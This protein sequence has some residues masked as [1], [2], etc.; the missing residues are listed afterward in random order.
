MIVERNWRG[1]AGEVDLIVTD[2]R[3]LVI[4]EVKARAD[5]RFGGAAAAVGP[6]KQRRLRALAA[7]F[8]AAHREHRGAVRFDVVAITGRH[9]VGVLTPSTGPG[10]QPRKPHAIRPTARAMAAMT[11]TM[12]DRRVTRRRYGFM[13]MP[14][15]MAAGSGCPVFGTQAH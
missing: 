4:A 7:E 11:K 3:T 9:R 5:D 13:P 6:V 1:A 10:R 14:I 15:S 2:G 12:S 8:L